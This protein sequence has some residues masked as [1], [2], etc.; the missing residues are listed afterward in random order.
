VQRGYR[1]PYPNDIDH[2]SE[3]TLRA[4]EG[5]IDPDE[6]PD[7]N[8][9]GAVKDLRHLSYKVP[10][11]ISWLILGAS[12]VGALAFPSL[13]LTAARLFAAYLIV[14]LWIKAVFYLVGLIR[15]RNWARRS[16]SHTTP[17]DQ[18][19]RSN[20]G[21]HVHHV[22]LI[23]NYKEPLGILQRTLNRLAQQEEAQRHLTVVLAMEE[24]EAEASAKARVLQRDFAHRFANFI[25]T[26]HPHDLPGEIPG[27]GANQAWAARRAKEELVE[28]LGMPLE[29]MTITSCDADSLLH[30]RY[31]SELARLFAADPQRHR[32]FWHAPVFYRNN[33]WYVPAPIRLLA[34]SAGAAHLS[35][36]TTSWA[37]PLPVS[38]YSLSFKLADEVGYW[39]P[40]VISE[41][42]HMYLR[43]FFATGGQTRLS[44]V[45]LPTS[46]DAV[47]GE[48]VWQAIASYYRQQ[49]RHAWGAEDVGYVLQQWRGARKT[50]VHRKIRCLTKVLHCHLLR[51]TSWFIIVLGAMLS[52]ISRGAAASL[53]SRQ[54][55]LFDPIWLMNALGTVSALAM[56]AMERTSSRSDEETL[57]LLLLA[58]EIAAWFLVMPVLSLFFSLPGLH[59]QTKL[60]F[61]SPLHYQQTPKRISSRPRS[62]G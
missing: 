15:C 52:G 22:V 40:A 27:K 28:R 29:Q 10:G 62:T 13:F 59:A 6:R 7:L 36:L 20:G 4:S 61:G 18:T 17:A 26:F 25:V 46:G 19:I 31:F 54:P 30:P 2:P 24:R 50:P 49:L 32:R 38:A 42:W 8:G 44:P 12:L 56:W 34:F 48:T 23:P 47:D 58:Q 14:R 55:L 37:W 57:S 43:C 33:I 9:L 60:L 21:D 16:E 51:S 5:A 11:L 1:S 35:E 3:T 53:P 41:D 39:D 45:F